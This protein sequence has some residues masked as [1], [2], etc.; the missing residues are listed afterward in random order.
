MTLAL[1]FSFLWEN[2]P[3]KTKE[4]QYPRLSLY[5]LTKSVFPHA[6][7]FPRPKF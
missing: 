4:R 6:L 5:D 1:R 3:I 2:S 7:H